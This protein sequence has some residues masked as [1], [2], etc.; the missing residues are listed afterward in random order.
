MEAADR[1]ID[2]IIDTVAAPHDCWTRSSARFAGTVPSSSWGLP[3]RRHAAG[4][5]GRPHPAADQ[6]HRLA[7][8]RNRRNPGDARFLRR[9]QVVADIE[10][11]R[12]DQLNEAYD[13]MVA[14]DVK[15]RFVLDTSTLQAPAEEAD[16]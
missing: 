2:V 7:D 12:A 16:A 8:R 14:G 1:S 9:A 11:V 4:K 10:L 3:V 15:Y 13:R 5:P 6:L